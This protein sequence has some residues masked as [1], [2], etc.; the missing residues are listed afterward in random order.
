MNREVL[1]AQMETGEVAR[2]A[3]NLNVTPPAA[4]DFK[5]PEAKAKVYELCTRLLAL[6]GRMAQDDAI[7]IEATERSDGN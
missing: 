1:D 2:V 7:T 4:P 6:R 3:R 5:N